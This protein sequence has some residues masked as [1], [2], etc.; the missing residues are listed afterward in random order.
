MSTPPGSGNPFDRIHNPA[1]EAEAEKFMDRGR[2]HLA[3]STNR[4]N[5]AP[6]SVCAEAA[7]PERTC[8][9]DGMEMEP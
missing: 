4:R 3:A 1:Q 8:V 6:V 5:D 7:E 9:V 2:E